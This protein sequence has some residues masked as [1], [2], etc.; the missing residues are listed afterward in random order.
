MKPRFL[1]V[2]SRLL[3]E[4]MRYSFRVSVVQ[5]VYVNLSVWMLKCK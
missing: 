5:W 4:N 2:V 3:T 1:W